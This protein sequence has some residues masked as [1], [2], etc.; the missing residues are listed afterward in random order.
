MDGLKC[1]GVYIMALLFTDDVGSAPNNL[2][3][4][5]N[6]TPNYF[7]VNPKPCS[8]PLIRLYILSILGK[9][10][11]QDVL[12]TPGLKRMPQYHPKPLD[13]VRRAWKSDT[14]TPDIPQPGFV[15]RTFLLLGINGKS[16]GELGSGGC[17][18]CEA[19]GLTA[20][21]PRMVWGSA[22]PQLDELI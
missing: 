16:S 18:V 21:Q 6:E 13:S 17:F 9:K 3:S 8:L 20:R 12:K 1:A 10:Y 14:S 5:Y 22:A 11:E 2:P 4:R 19:D 7:S 15:S